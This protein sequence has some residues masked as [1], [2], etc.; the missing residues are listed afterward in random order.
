MDS[1]PPMTP[2]SAATS[3]YRGPFRFPEDAVVRGLL[4]AEAHVESGLVAVERV[5]VLHDEL[6]HA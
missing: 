4:L 3:E 2:D 6:A 1:L 5:G